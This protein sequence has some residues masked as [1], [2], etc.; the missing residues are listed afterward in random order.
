MTAQLSPTPI[1]KGWDNN[2][3]PLA[4]GFLTTYAAG[5]VTP[6]ATYVDSTQTTQNT[7]PIQLNFRGECALWLNPL[8]SY[9]F[10]LTDAFG[11]TIPGW[12]V[13]NI[14]GAIG[15]ASNIIP[16]ITNTFTLGTPTVTFA[17]AYFGPN[18]A[19]V[20]DASNGGIGYFP[21]IAAETG[22]TITSFSLSYGN[23]KRYGAKGDGVTNDAAAL[24]T[25][26]AVAIAGVGFVYVPAATYIINST[27]TAQNFDGLSIYGDSAAI[28]TLNGSPFLNNSTLVFDGAGSGNDGL[29]CTAFVGVKIQNLA[30]SFKRGSAGGGRALR[31]YN[32]HDIEVDNVKVNLASGSAGQAITLGGGTGG[33]AAFIA[34]VSNC[35]VMSD[36]G[37][38]FVSNNANTS[39][40]FDTCYSIGGFYNVI[41]N[42]YS[43]LTNCAC[44]GAPAYAY[45]IQG[46][47]QGVTLI[48]C[49]AEIATQ[50]AIRVNNSSNVTIIAPVGS[51][52]NSSG[53][54]GYGCLVQLDS[55]GG[56]VSNVTVI[57]PVDISPN[58]ASTASIFG[59]TGTGTVQVINA[60]ANYLSKGIG[61]DTTWQLN[62]L[63]VE[64]DA[65]LEQGTWTPTLGT[66]WTNVGTP[67]L[68]GKYIKKGKLIAVFVSVTPATSIQTASLARINLPWSPTFNGALGQIDGNNLSYG[69]ATAGTTGQI[70]TQSTG[71]LTVPLYFQGSF[72][73][74]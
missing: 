9:K 12:P 24:N 67:T 57:N 5:T 59:T 58:A 21:R 2:G 28:T 50:G 43:S 33:T 47:C 48:A 73:I 8:L 41:G 20:F 15:V 70:F 36:G 65:N 46:G 18:G 29:V 52:N 60:N 17:N 45:T 34:K 25:A 61:G 54:T 27:V 30:I 69:I 37:A 53:G 71:V 1:F 19:P 31:I 11:N 42:V 74:A 7:N 3:F 62:Y 56:I 55:A 66:G 63:T 49:G 22:Q 35:K 51:S 13:D 26:I 4:L 16:S 64:G 14:Q 44:D 72:F 68:V 23:I 40:K 39:V 10:L 6:Q 32:G 38:A